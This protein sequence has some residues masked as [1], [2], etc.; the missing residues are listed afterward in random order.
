MNRPRTYKDIKALA[1]ATRKNVPELL[2]MSSN[3]DP[4][5]IMPAQVKQAEWFAALWTQFDLPTGVHLRRIHYRLVSQSSPFCDVNGLPYENTEKCWQAMTDA[6]KSA[7]SL[8]LVA[9]DAFVDMRNPDPS[10]FCNYGDKKIPYTELGCFCWPIP[11]IEDSLSSEIDWNIPDVNV[12]GYAPD[13]YTRPFHLELIS[14][15]STMDEIIV[16]L[17]KELKVNYAPFTGFASITGSIAMLKRLRQANKPSIVFYVSDFDPAGSFMPPS[18][19]RQ[20]EFWLDTYAPGAD[21]LLLPI[22]LTLEQ[23]KHYKLPGIPIKDSDKRQN[24]FLENNDVKG[25]T[26]LDALEAIYPGELEKILRQAIKPYCDVNANSGAWMLD[27]KTRNS[28]CSH[29]NAICRPYTWRIN[30][31]RE[32]AQEIVEG[33]E[34]ELRTLRQAMNDDLK[35]IEQELERL[36]QAVKSEYDEF[37]PDLPDIYESPLKLPKQFDGLFDSRRDYLTQIEF[38]NLK[39]PKKRKKSGVSTCKK[40]RERKKSNV[41]TLQ[42]L[43]A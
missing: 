35:P 38:Y 6:S 42:Q 5:Y 40:L 19:A 14:E 37:E 28:V 7:R 9:A 3:N 32:Q 29:W 10:I 36:R 15:K 34:D 31:L 39:N 25:A 4:F 23:V 13:N 27:V 2:A 30:L 18:V 41:N 21:V 16:P 17:C 22:A 26:E 1:K 8:G 43:L 12:F 20:L 11:T 33:Y 24:K